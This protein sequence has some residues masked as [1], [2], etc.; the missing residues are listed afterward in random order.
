MED[1]HVLRLPNS[2]FQDLYLC[3]CGVSEC[4][5]CHSFGPAVRPSYI[6]HYVLSGKGIYQVG[7]RKYKI[8]KGQGFLIE[9]EA[10]TFYQADEQEPWTYL[11]VGFAGTHAEMFLQDLGL[12]GNQHVFQNRHEEELKRIVANML[13]NH[14]FSQAHQYYLQS[15]LYEFFAVLSRD[16]QMEAVT[17]ENRESIYVQKAVSYIQNNYFRG[18]GVAEI[19]EHIGVSRSYL[20]KVFSKNLQVSPKEFLTRLRLVRSRELLELT[21]LSIEGVAMSCG[22]QDTLVFS[23]AFKQETGMPPS[24]YRKMYHRKQQERNLSGS[25]GLLEIVETF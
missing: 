16:V 25:Q 2:K 13:K 10:V 15:L 23:K 4:E 17:E 11:W 12:N 21:E 22:Y 24:H 14:T 20:Y 18:I 7:G 8:R 9:P 5:P 1:A 6:L 3:F 19:A